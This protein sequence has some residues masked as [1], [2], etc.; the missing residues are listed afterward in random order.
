[1]YRFTLAGHSNVVQCDTLPADRIACGSIAP[2]ADL[3]QKPDHV[4]TFIARNFYRQPKVFARIF[5]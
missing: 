2:V 3:V 5:C 1:M 4:A